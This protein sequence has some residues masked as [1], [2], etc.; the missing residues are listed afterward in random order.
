M[1]SFLKRY[2]VGTRLITAFTA[3]FLI[4]VF[5]AGMGIYNMSRL[6][7]AGE[8]IV[9]VNEE[10]MEPLHDTLDSA[11]AIAISLRN[12]ILAEDATRR[13]QQIQ[14]TADHRAKY[15]ES[16]QTYQQAMSAEDAPHVKV[17]TD[18]LAEAVRTNDI[19]IGLVK[20]GRSSDAAAAL[21]MH[22]E[23]ANN[24]LIA[25]LSTEVN[26]LGARPAQ[27]LAQM[28]AMYRTARNTMLSVV[29]LTVVAG[30]GLAWF[31][32][33]SLTGPLSQA[34]RIADA[35]ANGDLSNRI[36]IDGN[37][38]TTDLLRAFERMQNTLNN[39][40][41]AQR[42]VGRE[43]E[44]GFISRKIDVEKF[45]GVFATAAHEN[46]ELVA[47]HIGVKMRVIEVLSHYANGDF[48]VDM[49]RLP[50]EKAV[51]TETMDKAQAN[52]RAIQNE[53]LQLVETAKAGELDKRGDADKFSHGFRAMVGGINDTLDAI[54][55]PV[56]EV[57]A[58][59]GALAQGDLTRRIERS[60]PGDYGRMRDDANATVEQLSRILNG[61]RGSADSIATASAEIASGNNDLSQR[62]EQQ[63]AS[64]E[65]TASS[66]EE[67]TATVR[68]NAEHARQA[69][70]LALN[71]GETAEAGGKVVSEVVTTMGSISESSR[72]ISDIIGVID[73]IAF[74]TNI[75]ALTAAVEAARAGEQG[76]GFAVVAS[77]VR[78]LAQRS[79]QAAKEIKSLIEDSVDKV[80]AGSALVSRAGNTMAE[81]VTSVKRVTDIMADISAASSEQSAGIEQVNIAITQMDEGTQQ[82]AAL[83]EE[84]SAATRSLE[85]QAEELREAVAIFRLGQ[86]N[87]LRSA[88]P[89]M[90]KPASP[91]KP[92]TPR[93]ASPARSITPIR[94]TKRAVSA[95]SVA[96][97]NDSQEWQEF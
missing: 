28:Q 6:N 80:D 47:A 31:L 17:L 63:A 56:R 60:Y 39:F 51:I 81:V 40:V 22:A 79:A 84:A 90:A 68:Q 87:Q 52:L 75:L 20:E 58:V 10:A 67:L 29:L 88:A 78:N 8:H 46:N 82:N 13:S 43:H 50:E 9:S 38:E 94:Q 30:I 72:K 37:D 32:I 44:K 70:Q 55:G 5:T 19:V 95:A 2:R 97:S 89:A 3:L 41:E 49:D 21:V 61:I 45:N 14:A 92:A 64:L 4:M 77:E 27:E 71:A 12:M 53:I 11:N 23:P 15:R 16:F 25:G 91:S 66:M 85:M 36:T 73:G 76:R 18:L 96:A 86:E 1:T 7:E 33:R 35:V 42:E 74:Q 48:D 54:V 24:A 65:E 93:P 26:R 57:Q 59:L 83:V 69:N 34:T 62:T